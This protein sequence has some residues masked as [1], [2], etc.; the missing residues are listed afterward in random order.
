METAT[1]EQMRDKR[2][3]EEDGS[4]L[5]TL[6]LGVHL[7][8]NVQQLFSALRTEPPSI[9]LESRIYFSTMDSV[10]IR[11]KRKETK[12]TV[13]HNSCVFGS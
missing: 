11:S 4:T 8:Q 5:R 6:P 2:E 3:T 12:V 9:V 13:G 10:L 7:S 1:E